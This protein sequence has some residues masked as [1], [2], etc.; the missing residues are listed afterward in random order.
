MCTFQSR[1]PLLVGVIL[2]ALAM[3]TP[4]ELF[5]QRG[6]SPGGLTGGA[7][8]RP[9]ASANQRV[10]RN[11]THARDYAR[12]I[13]HYSR[14]SG[15]IEPTVAKSESDDLGKRI[16]QAQK[17]LT[18]VREE[19]GNDPDVSKSLKTIESHLA[20]A[21]QQQSMLFKECCKESVDGLACMKHCNQILL[22]LDKAQAEHDALMR[23]MEIRVQSNE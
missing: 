4:V 15:A 1:G 7:R 23:S 13:Y 19:V 10:S 18:V 14:D 9:G 12:D 5:A 20:T 17:E 6:K 2:T 11:V 3:A 8:L 21:E 16:S 22:E